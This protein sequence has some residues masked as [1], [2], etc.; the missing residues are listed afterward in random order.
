MLPNAP[1]STHGEISERFRAE[2]CDSFHSACRWLQELAYGF[3]SSDEDSTIVFTERCGTC[4]TKHG[5]AARLATELGLDVDRYEGFYRLDG[6]IIP[7]CADVLA[8]KGWAYVPRTH[9]FLQ[10]GLLRVDL[11]DGNCHG[12]SRLPNHYDVVVRVK[13]DHD[14]EEWRAL[15]AWGLAWI[16]RLDSFWDGIP[17]D[18]IIETLSECIDQT[19]LTCVSAEE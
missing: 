5:I 10:C 7:G 18:E 11:T 19:S 14:L 2:G 15:Y 4:P 13:P 17:D 9:C 6:S 3:N 12:K 1:L 8:R 16:R